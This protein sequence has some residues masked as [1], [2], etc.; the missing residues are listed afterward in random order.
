MALARRDHGGT[1]E[2]VLRAR[3][4]LLLH[5]SNRKIDGNQKSEF[6][7]YLY[8]SVGKVGAHTGQRLLRKAHDVVFR[9]AVP[10]DEG[11]VLRGQAKLPNNSDFTIANPN[12]ISNSRT[13]W[14]WSLLELLG[15]PELTVQLALATVVILARQQLGPRQRGT[16]WLWMLLSTSLL[17]SSEFSAEKA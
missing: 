3:P 14:L 9:L 17:P 2:A 16:D 6:G 12:H 5:M 13:R 11:C 10:A 4:D 1:A 15:D 8:L 7:V